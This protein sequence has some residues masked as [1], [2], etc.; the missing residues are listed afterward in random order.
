MKGWGEG[1]KKYNL[2]PDLNYNLKPIIKIKA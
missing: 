2:K 1:G